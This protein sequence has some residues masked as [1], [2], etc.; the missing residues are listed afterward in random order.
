[1]ASK[2]PK[3]DFSP[4]AIL[5]EIR[6]GKELFNSI[7]SLKSNLSVKKVSELLRLRC[8]ENDIDAASLLSLMFGFDMVSW[9]MATIQHVPRV[10]SRRKNSCAKIIFEI[11]NKL[12]QEKHLSLPVVDEMVKY[13]EE[14]VPELNV[15]E[16]QQTRF[17]D[18]LSSLNGKDGVNYGGFIAPPV[19]D[20]MLRGTVLTSPN[21]LSSCTLY[22]VNGPKPCTN[23]SLR[24]Q[25]CKVSYGR[26]MTHYSSGNA[27]Y[28]PKEIIR[29]DNLV[30]VTNV[31]YMEKKLY[32]WIPSLINHCFVSFEDFSISY[33]EVYCEEIKNNF[34]SACDALEAGKKSSQNQIAGF[35]NDF[36]NVDVLMDDGTPDVDVPMICDSADDIISGINIAS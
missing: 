3:V 26:S 33:N 36:I 6:K 32:R 11:A 35:S 22:T 5:R 23:L 4:E 10:F 18:A 9:V 31:V 12:C 28:Y 29:K 15:L 1:M 2:R 7:N 30:E 24:C 14:F 25:G 8:K 17:E 20:C 16:T 19:E 27:S 13:I 34:K 21:A